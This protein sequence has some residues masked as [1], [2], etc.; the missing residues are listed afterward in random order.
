ADEP[1]LFFSAPACRFLLISR[2]EAYAEV[3]NSPPDDGTA[4]VPSDSVCVAKTAAK[5][6]GEGG[7]LRK[8]CER[9]FELADRAVS[10]G[11]GALRLWLPEGLE[12]AE[13]GEQAPVY[14][15]FEKDDF[16]GISESSSD[17]PQTSRRFLLPS[18]ARIL[19]ASRRLIFGAPQEL[20]RQCG[21]G[22][23]A[24]SEFY[25]CAVLFSQAS[26][27]LEDVVAV[28]RQVGHDVNWVART[29]TRW[30]A[31]SLEAGSRLLAGSILGVA[32]AAT[33]SLKA[34]DVRGMLPEGRFEVPGAA[35]EVAS[36]ARVVSQ[37]MASLAGDLAFH[38]ASVVGHTAGQLCREL[39]ANSERWHEDL[40]V[41]GR[42]S[43]KAGAEV[44]QAVE[45]AT[46]HVALGVAETSAEA[47]GHSC[48]DDAKEVFQDTVFAVANVL[49][50]K[51]NLSG[52]GLAQLS[53]LSSAKE[54]A[55]APVAEPSKER[56][57]DQR[58]SA[59]V[60]NWFLSVPCPLRSEDAVCDEA[61]PEV[62]EVALHDL[63]S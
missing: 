30:A 22:T 18:S 61:M 45:A 48:G 32:Q 57:S 51:R 56:P 8:A 40:R 37:S 20:V 29:E 36:G 33:Q 49:E 15:L 14:L 55:G 46:G 21:L 3:E 60:S 43:L 59:E 16:F 17:A 54:L 12:A 58:P 34:C 10:L 27:G 7:A 42:S 25:I 19:A 47:V 23:S 38:L 6:Y 44:F 62:S 31:E 4:N 9:A 11:A 53:A 39:P 5:V 26:S 52:K 13:P 1:G 2:Q 24:Q 35:R 63:D 28:L 41:I 50:V